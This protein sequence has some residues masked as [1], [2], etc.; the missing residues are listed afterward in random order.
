MINECC[1]T[2]SVD[3]FP[4][5]DCHCYYLA[6]P[7][8]SLCPHQFCRVHKYIANLV[9]ITHNWYTALGRNWL[10]T[11]ESYAS[12]SMSSFRKRTN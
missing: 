6:M 8:I 1:L 4:L 11:I 2:G 3:G 12:M 10:V 9:F 5:N 7:E